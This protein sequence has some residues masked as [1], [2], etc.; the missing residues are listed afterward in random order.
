ML[1][2]PSMQIDVEKAGCLDG[3]C[4]IYSMW[5][6]YLKDE[7]QK[8]FLAWLES[9]G[10]PLH[11][12]HTSGHASLR[13]LKRLRTAF[14]SAKVVPIHCAEPELFEKD[15]ERVERHLDNEW[16]EVN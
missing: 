7:K 3:A 5:D 9:C 10:I 1:F 14:E 6:G 16:W 2:R 8:P 13:D 11:K 12:C 4:L 15:F